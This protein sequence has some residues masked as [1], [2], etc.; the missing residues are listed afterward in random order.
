LKYRF[1]VPPCHEE[2]R[3]RFAKEKT[4]V[5]RGSARTV[6]DTIAVPGSTLGLDMMQEIR[7]ASRGL[8]FGLAGY[9]A[10]FVVQ[11][12]SYFITHMLAILAQAFATLA[13]AVVAVVVL[14]ALAWSQKPVDM[15]LRWRRGRRRNA[16]ALI[17]ATFIIL[18]LSVGTLWKALA[19]LIRGGGFRTVNPALAIAVLAVGML[20]VNFPVFDIVRSAK[21]G[22]SIRLRLL[23]LI[24]DEVCYAAGI[25]GIAL[26]AAGHTWADPAASLVIGAAISVG[27]ALLIRDCILLL[28]NRSARPS[29]AG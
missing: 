26:A 12:T 8:A 3:R 13:N 21:E 23:S 7:R 25:V 28:K 4:I 5:R 17:A 10:I 20:L 22:S 6:Q 27:A 14:L 18:F 1:T 24:K 9:T 16:V 29:T 15:Y 19:T 11:L 2:Q